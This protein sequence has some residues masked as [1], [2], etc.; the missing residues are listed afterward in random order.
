MRSTPLR[1]VDGKIITWTAGA[2]LARRAY[3]THDHPLPQQPKVSPKR[4][5]LAVRSVL[6]QSHGVHTAFQLECRGRRWEWKRHALGMRRRVL[7]GPTAPSPIADAHKQP[8]I[9]PF[10]TPDSTVPI[11]PHLPENSTVPARAKPPT[12]LGRL[13]VIHWGVPGCRVPQH[14]PIA[15]LANLTESP[16]TLQRAPGP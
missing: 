3:G 16:I 11:S 8:S 13:R 6:F 4:S 2:C 5:C 1:D 9:F 7:M 15:C 12:Q 14:I 10:L